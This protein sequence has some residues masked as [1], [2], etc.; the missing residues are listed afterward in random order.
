[1]SQDESDMAGTNIKWNSLMD[2]GQLDVALIALI[3]AIAPL[4]IKFI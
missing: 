2:M 4:S 1:M 3:A